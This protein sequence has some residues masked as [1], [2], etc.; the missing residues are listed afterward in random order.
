MEDKQCELIILHVEHKEGKFD[1]AAM[2]YLDLENRRVLLTSLHAE[3]G[4]T[5]MDNCEK[6][7]AA[8][9]KA[10]HTTDASTLASW[11]GDLWVEISD[12]SNSDFS[13]THL[14][15]AEADYKIAYEKSKVKSAAYHKFVDHEFV[16]D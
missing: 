15:R 11:L 1:D 14:V 4:E 5:G 12:G 2:V 10:H 8:L 13:I 7:L 16:Q 3:D 6:I 9:L